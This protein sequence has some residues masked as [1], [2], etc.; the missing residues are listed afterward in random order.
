MIRARW[1]VLAVCIVI[2]VVSG[3]AHIPGPAPTQRAIYAVEHSQQL[4]AFE[5]GYNYTYV[6]Y[7]D[8]PSWDYNPS[9][10]LV[11]P[12]VDLAHSIFPFH[13][14]FATTLVFAPKYKLLG[15]G[16]TTTVAVILT[17][18]LLATVNP[19]TGKIYSR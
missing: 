12:L 3:V 6:G 16:N 11:Q 19:T 4:L 15:Y 13:S 14:Y 17:T 5:N 9:R 18:I 1:V 8:D 10:C 2:A 7:T